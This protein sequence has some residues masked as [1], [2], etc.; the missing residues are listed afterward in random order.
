M[1]DLES[2]C[3]A[4]KQA[5]PVPAAGRPFSSCLHLSLLLTSGFLHSQERGARPRWGGTSGPE[6]GLVC[7]SVDW[8]HTPGA[9]EWFGTLLL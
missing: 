1:T 8:P 9:G 5:V 3:P 4:V 6:P 7:R 2:A